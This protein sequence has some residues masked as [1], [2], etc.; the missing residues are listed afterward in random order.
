MRF[1]QKVR[2]AIHGAL[3]LA[4]SIVIAFIIAVYY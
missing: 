2:I 4:L 1:W 3:L